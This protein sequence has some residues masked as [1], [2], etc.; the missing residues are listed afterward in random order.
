[1]IR[2]ELRIYF[3][4]GLFW[5]QLLLLPKTKNEKHIERNLEQWSLMLRQHHVTAL[6]LKD[7]DGLAS[8]LIGPDNCMAL[9]AQ[10]DRNHHRQNHCHETPHNRVVLLQ[11]SPSGQRQLPIESIGSQR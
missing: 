5:L 11:G 4:P 1:M 2:N 10:Q 8:A 9:V 6:R 3:L 7:V